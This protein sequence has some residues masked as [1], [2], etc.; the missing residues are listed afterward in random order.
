M[1]RL[2]VREVLKNLK[3]NDAKR[4]TRRLQ[5]AAL[6]TARGDPDALENQGVEAKLG[7]PPLRDIT[8]SC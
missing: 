3:D 5:R 2:R 8:A 4:V 7:P 1:N 6:T